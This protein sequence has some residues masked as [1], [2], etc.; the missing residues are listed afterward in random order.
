MRR[1]ADISDMSSKSKGDTGHTHMEALHNYCMPINLFLFDILN[2]SILHKDHVL[3]SFWH[4][5]H[6]Y[7]GGPS[8]LF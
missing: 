3:T 6:K 4:F 5:A 2:G 7:L 1:P 8:E